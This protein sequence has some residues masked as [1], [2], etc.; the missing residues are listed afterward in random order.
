MFQPSKVVP[1]FFQPQYLVEESG[2]V[3]DERWVL[4]GGHLESF[5]PNFE[6]KSYNPVKK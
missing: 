4:F 3:F 1:D 5:R 2:A 6:A